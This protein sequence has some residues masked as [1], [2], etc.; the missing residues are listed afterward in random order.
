M[1][2]PLIESDVDLAPFNTFGVAARASRFATICSTEDLLEIVRL[3]RGAPILPLG[4]GSNVLFVGH[5]EALLVRNLISGR[6]VIEETPEIVLVE[7]GGGENWSEAV[8]WCVERG[9]GGV[10][11]L[12]LIPG[13]V[14][15][16]PIQ[17]IGA[18]GAELADVFV[19]LEAVNLE[20]GEV[21]TLDKPA[22]RFGY[23]ESVFKR[24][25]RE[26]AFITSVT[27]Q[28]RR[29]SSPN[30]KYADVERTL[31]AAGVTV[32]SIKD[33]CDAVEAIRR[34]KLPDPA[35]LGNAGSFFKNPEIDQA[36][37]A[38]LKASHPAI[39]GYPGA[40]RIKVPAAWLI[41]QCGWKGRRVG[42]VSCYENQPLV[43][44]N[45]GG[46]TGEE[47]LAHA[48]AVIRSVRERF[49]IELTPEVNVIGGRAVTG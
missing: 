46:A 35:V 41:E 10:E 20:N 48:R 19:R 23:R 37:H 36:H 25:W 44:V 15:A 13:T 29:N 42:R 28:L 26:R 22:C 9:L 27:L 34:A 21:F 4:G 8:R 33:A 5:P 49:E 3:E 11:N 39:P 32:P 6:R 31:A 18:Y 14:G 17:N 24:A 47:I 1:T 12:I 43:I 7:F 38:L 16:A 30:V 40:D 45:H 2:R